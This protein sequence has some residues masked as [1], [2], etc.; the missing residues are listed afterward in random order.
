MS[1]RIIGAVLA[2]VF[3]AATFGA[4]AVSTTVV[5]GSGPDDPPTTC[6]APFLECGDDDYGWTLP[7]T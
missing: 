6:Q 1:K 2:A 3:A 5:L 7:G 4:A